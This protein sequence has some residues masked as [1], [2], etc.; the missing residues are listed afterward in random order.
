MEYIGNKMANEFYEKYWTPQD[1]KPSHLDPMNG[2]KQF[3]LNKYLSQAYSPK[4]E[5][6]PAKIFIENRKKGIY[7]GEYHLLRYSLIFQRI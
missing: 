3:I 6:S 4:G 7:P 5:F 1:Y 2:R